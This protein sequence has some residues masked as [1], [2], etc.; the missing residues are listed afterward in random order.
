MNAGLYNLLQSSRDLAACLL[1]QRHLE[2]ATKV[3]SAFYVQSFLTTKKIEGF[4]EI[5]DGYASDGTG[6]VMMPTQ[7]YLVGRT[8]MAESGL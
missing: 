4:T 6:E 7:C 2:S 5:E 8:G 1:P 3:V